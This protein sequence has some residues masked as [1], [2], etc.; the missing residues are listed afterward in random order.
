[1]TTVR[2]IPLV[3]VDAQLLAILCSIIALKGGGRS[4]LTYFYIHIRILAWRK[5]EL[6]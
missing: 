5:G 1:M 4:Y 6:V 2:G 3:R